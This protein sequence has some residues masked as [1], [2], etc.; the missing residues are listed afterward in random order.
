MWNRNTLDWDIRPRRAF[1]SF[2]IKQWSKLKS[3]L[4]APNSNHG[5]DTPHWNLC[6]G[7]SFQYCIY[8]KSHTWSL[9]K[10]M[11]STPIH[12]SSTTYGNLASPKNVSECINIAENLQKRPPHWNLNPSWCVLCKNHYQDIHLFIT[13]VVATNI[14][15]KV[16]HLINR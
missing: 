4:Y 7:W 2:E 3:F 6:S 13:C 10:K 5:Y 11:K 12:L 8:Q 14:W 9:I 16:E 15:E 1:R